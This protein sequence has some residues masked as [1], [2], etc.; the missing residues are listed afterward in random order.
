MTAFPILTLGPL[1]TPTD[2]R[3]LSSQRVEVLLNVSAID[4]VEIYEA[5]LLHCFELHSFRFRDIFSQTSARQEDWEEFKEQS[6]PL[7]DEAV[8]TLAN[9]LQSGRRVHCFCSEG[10]SRSALTAAGALV[11]AF[12]LEPDVA[13]EMISLKNHRAEFSARSRWYLDRLAFGSSAEAGERDR[14]TA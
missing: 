5:E 11:L 6:L 2:L 8:R 1:V 7:V 10:R 4:I 9:V 13:M 14:M 3:K 12:D